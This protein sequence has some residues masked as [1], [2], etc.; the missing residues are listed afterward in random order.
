MKLKDIAL[1]CGLALCASASQAAFVSYNTTISPS[2]TPFST[3]FTTQ[4][5]D[6]TL[7]TLTGINLSLTSNVLA[8]LNVFNAGASATPFTNGQVI[9][10]ITVTATTPDATS[11]TAAAT[12]FQ[13]TGTALA[14]PGSTT[15]FSGLG[16]TGSNSVTVAP[17]NFM[18]YIGM[19][20]GL[21]T[22]NASASNGNYSGTGPQNLFFGGSATADGSFTITYT[23]DTPTAV[24]LPAAAW[25]LGSGLVSL[26]AAARRRR[27]SA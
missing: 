16:A 27:R 4:L 11:V 20:G 25:L 10:P 2:N 19:G 24:P 12:A 9:L 17:V 21:A 1:A 26:G 6:S 7:G 14:G 8:T 18:N 3:S 22:F 13:A 5:F 23:Y 15:S